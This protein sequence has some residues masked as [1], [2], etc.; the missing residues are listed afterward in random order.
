[1]NKQ[2]TATWKAAGEEWKTVS[3]RS[4]LARLKWMGKD[5]SDLR[6]HL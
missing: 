6:S 5:G 4:V 1:M 2:A 3:S